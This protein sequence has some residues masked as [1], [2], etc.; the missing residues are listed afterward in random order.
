MAVINSR[1]DSEITVVF[2]KRGLLMWHASF[3]QAHRAHAYEAATMDLGHSSI[4]Y[5][6]WTTR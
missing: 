4:A 5:H 1:E 3:R 6:V 2:C